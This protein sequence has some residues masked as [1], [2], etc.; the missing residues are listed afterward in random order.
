[1]APPAGI[2]IFTTAETF[3]LAMIA[4]RFFSCVPAPSGRREI[5]TAQ[6]RL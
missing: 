5:L 4:T 1:L 6:S 2:W 3:F